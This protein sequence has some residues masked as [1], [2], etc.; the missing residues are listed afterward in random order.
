MAPHGSNRLLGKGFLESANQTKFLSPIRG[1]LVV[2]ALGR[3]KA[4]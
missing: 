2:I 1:Y 4:Y 3:E